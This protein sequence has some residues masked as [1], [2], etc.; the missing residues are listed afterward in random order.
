MK[1]TSKDLP[2]NFFQKIFFFSNFE[3]LNSWC[4]Q[5]TYS[6]PLANNVLNNFRKEPIGEDVKKPLQDKD[7][8]QLPPRS[9]VILIVL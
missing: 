6:Y 9:K 8:N 4:G 1:K 7:V 5:Q 2:L 3:L